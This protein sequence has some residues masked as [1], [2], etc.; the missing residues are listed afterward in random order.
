MTPFASVAMLEKFALL[1]I[2]FCSAPATGNRDGIAEGGSALLLRRSVLSRLMRPN[3]KAILHP[4]ANAQET[5]RSGRKNDSVWQLSTPSLLQ[6]R[7]NAP[8]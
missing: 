2:A 5:A 3:M 8:R 7:A 1:K 4:V 6:I